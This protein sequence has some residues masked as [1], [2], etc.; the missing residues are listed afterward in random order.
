MLYLDRNRRRVAEG[1]EQAHLRHYL[2][3]ATYLAWM[4]CRRLDLPAGQTP[5]QHFLEHAKV[6]LSEG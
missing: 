1:A 3:E 5:Q 6:G 4:D 2:P